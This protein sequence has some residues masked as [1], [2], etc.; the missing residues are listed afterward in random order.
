LT[1]ALQV[2]ATGTSQPGVRVFLEEVGRSSSGF[3][4]YASLGQGGPALS[5]QWRKFTIPFML[6]TDSDRQLRVRIDVSA[7]AEVWIDELQ[8]SEPPLDERTYQEVVFQINL[9]GVLL[10]KGKYSSAAHLLEGYW[11]R[12]LLEHVA[13]QQVPRVAA[14]QNQEEVRDAVKDAPDPGVFDRLRRAVP[15]IWRF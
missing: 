8:L 10:D 15:K 4:R 2:R 6:P 11:P 1:C 3:A 13:V 5:D 9:A 12:F 14:R 7:D